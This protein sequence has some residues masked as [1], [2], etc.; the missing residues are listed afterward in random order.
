MITWTKVVM[1]MNDAMA[2][3][4]KVEREGM[5]VDGIWRVREKAVSGVILV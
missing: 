1:E 4:E 5:I 2:L 3:G